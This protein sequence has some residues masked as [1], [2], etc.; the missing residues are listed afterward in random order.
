MAEVITFAPGGYRYIKGPFQYSA[1]VAAEPGF[2]IERVH[3]IKPL[4][5]AE[6]FAAIE[7]HLAAAG[8]PLTSFCACESA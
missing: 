2:E 1:G 4:R 3:Y 7:A 8:R 5:L 6:G